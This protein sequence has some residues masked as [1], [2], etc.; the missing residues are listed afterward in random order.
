MLRYFYLVSFWFHSV[1]EDVDTDFA[2][3]EFGEGV[4]FFDGVVP[5]GEAPDADIGAV[6]EDI[7]TRAGLVGADEV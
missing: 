2:G 4:D 1:R 7:A 3:R 5:H 6:N